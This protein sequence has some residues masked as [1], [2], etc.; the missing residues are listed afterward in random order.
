MK[1]S[2]SPFVFLVSF[3]DLL[4]LAQRR[5]TNVLLR[6]K[7]LMTTTMI[8]CSSARLNKTKKIPH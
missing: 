1:G 2:E 3:S 7:K 6:R 4:G 8:F 5:Q